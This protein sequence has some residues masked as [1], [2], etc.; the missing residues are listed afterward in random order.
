[1]ELKNVALAS[2]LALGLTVTGPALAQSK[3]AEGSKSQSSAQSAKS[4]E[5]QSAKSSES[6]NASGGQTA[7]TPLE[8]RTEREPQRSPSWLGLLGLLGLA[9]LLRRRT[10]DRDR[11]V[12][13]GTRTGAG[14]RRVGVYDK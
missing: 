5:S 7:G 2:I 8:S 10:P 3:S 14:E 9:G 6:D 13:V 11:D 1:M 4:S 12:S